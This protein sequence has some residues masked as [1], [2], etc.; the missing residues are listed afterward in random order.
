MIKLSRT[1]PSF[2]FLLIVL[3]IPPVAIGGGTNTANE[4]VHWPAFDDGSTP[5]G[6][7][8]HVP[9]EVQSS[10]RTQ[11]HSIIAKSQAPNSSAPILE[12]KSTTLWGSVLDFAFYEDYIIA[13][14]INGLQV[15]AQSDKT[16]PIAHLP[17]PIGTETD[18][19]ELRDNILFVGRAFECHIIDISNP[20]AP[21]T[22]SV[23]TTDLRV[24]DIQIEGDRLYLGLYLPD[25]APGGPSFHVYDISNLSAPSL[26]G[27]LLDDY[28][29]VDS[30]DIVVIDSFAYII[31]GYGWGGIF[32][33]SVSL[34]DETNPTLL[35]AL[36][37]GSRAYD[38]ARLGNFI[39]VIRNDGIAVYDISNPVLPVQ[40]NLVTNGG[41]NWACLVHGNSWGDYLLV[42][43]YA[44]IKVYDLSDP[45]LPILS[46]AFATNPIWWEVWF[47]METDGSLLYL[48]QY[49]DGFHVFNINSPVFAWLVEDYKCPTW[50]NSGVAVNGQWCY[51]SQVSAGGGWGHALHVLD[52]SDHSNPQHTSS[53]SAG[54][55]SPR[56][57]VVNNKLGVSTLGTGMMLY[58]LSDPAQP[59]RTGVLGE[60]S[61]HTFLTTDLAFV[62]AAGISYDI[63]DIS[64]VS[65]PQF[66]A[67]AHAD[68]FSLTSWV[69]SGLAFLFEFD[70]Y[71]SPPGT[72]TYLRV[73]DVSDPTN[74][75]TLN[76][77]VV[78][79]GESHPTIVTKVGNYLFEAQSDSGLIIIDVSDPVQPVVA[80]SYVPMGTGI[81]DL[82]SVDSFLFVSMTDPP[83][84]EILNISV[85]LA[86]VSVEYALY[87]SAVREIYV[88]RYHLYASTADGFYIYSTT[89]P[90]VCG[91]VDYSGDGPD[92]SDL[93]YLVDFMFNDGPEPTY[94]ESGDVDGSGEP[95]NIADLVYLVDFMFNGGPA[96][97][98]L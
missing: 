79:D 59:V 5:P 75:Q 93:V 13:L 48:P 44:G 15:F 71:W 52:I 51:V 6:M 31:S 60:A 32:L 62:C 61:Y 11:R 39:Y 54:A 68:R 22:L 9:P 45:S 92:I 86:P 85:P 26:I 76:E 96:P 89:F 72:P 63:F 18:Q 58:D 97:V 87:P 29:Y 94:P 30:W 33:K 35:S 34:A 4:S 28:Q 38:M 21:V 69:D 88:D 57:T 7:A 56:A 17:I 41:G 46:G 10:N 8:W 80:A 65:Y 19:L 24:R 25:N 82:C 67:S 78:A 49:R 42:R 20:L 77:I 1:N 3:M 53:F 90:T 27:I 74:P 55:A 16:T 95:I 37:M 66:L 84:V 43:T 50:Q 40:V 14:S 64:D 83:V 73:I 47:G 81:V 36:F 23:I 2:C 70:T 98:C 91:D 12:F